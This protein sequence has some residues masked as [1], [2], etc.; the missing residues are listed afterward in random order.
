MAPVAWCCLEVP[1]LCRECLADHHGAALSLQ[2]V[3]KPLNSDC[4]PFIHSF[5]LQMMH[6]LFC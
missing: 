6:I 1:C 2:M 3:P 4:Y 5:F